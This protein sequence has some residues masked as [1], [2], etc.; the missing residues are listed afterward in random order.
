MMKNETFDK[1]KI[2][3]PNY[4]DIDEIQNIISSSNKVAIFGHVNPDLDCYGAMYGA[5]YLCERLGA[6]AHLFAINSDKSFLNDIFDKSLIERDFDSSKFDL[7][8]MVDC[9]EFSRID[10]KF[11]EAVQNFKNILVIDHHEHSKIENGCKFFIQSHIC[12]ASMIIANLLFS[13]K[14][15]L[16]KEYAEYLFAG[17][18]GDTGRFLH[19]NTDKDTFKCALKLMEHDIDIQR[20]YDIVYRS[21]TIEQINMQ[22]FLLNNYHI[23]GKN[24]CYI[25][26]TKKVFKKLHATPEDLKF[27]VNDLNTIKDF[28]VVMVAYEVEHNKYKVSCRSK[29]GFIVSKIAQKYGGG[30]HKVAAG[31]NLFGNKSA[32]VRKLKKICLEF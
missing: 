16:N 15:K 11:R 12:A 13:Y 10:I 3:A 2:S 21:V 27:F 19:T 25:V 22:K 23:I 6:E 14:I 5:K 30:G 4:V 18:V 28:N 17:I 9:N 8:L 29:N 32:V 26:V 1:D 20:I 7:V 31:F 24:I